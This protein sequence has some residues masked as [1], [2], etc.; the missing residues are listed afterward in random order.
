[1]GRSALLQRLSCLA[2][3]RDDV[4]VLRA[5]AAP[6]EQDF[7]FGVV[8]Q[9]FE[10][11]LGDSPEDARDRWMDA[12]A[13]FARHVLADDAA[14]PGA[15]Q[16][17]AATEAVL[18]GLL[19]LLAN[20]SADSRLLILVDDLQWSDVPSLRWLTYLAKRLHGLRAVVVCALR[21]GDPRSHHTLVREI[22][23]AAT[24]TLRPASLSLTAT[25]ELVREHFGE[26]GDD[27][28]V[29][30]CHEASVGNPLFLMSIL[31]GTGFLGRRP[32]AE[33]A[34]TARRL[35][36]SQLRERLASIL[37]TQRPGP[38][39]RRRHRDPRRTERR[40]HPGQTG[41]ARLDRLRGGPA[42]PRRARCPRRPRRTALHPPVRPRRRRVHPHHGPAG[43]DARR[44][45]RP[46]LRRRLPGRTGRRPAHGRRHQAPAVGRRRAAGRRRH[47]AAPRRP[48]TAAG[49]L[50]RALLDSPAA[51]VGRGRLLVEL[52]TAERGSTPS[53]ANATSPRP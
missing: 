10:T 50:C 14:P 36:P 9:L 7:A 22:R 42:R 26:A 24:Q 27:E 28:F 47:R 29:Q 16:A 34:E 3:D 5:H 39:P 4:R 21:D 11:L 32:L 31:V 44:G 33:H 53:P 25:Q 8:R 17:I 12:H 41:R 38:R 52:G 35:R 46:P 43:A 6:M 49:Y 51:G 19:S 23:E 45:R 1:M 30:A 37:R 48:D 2:D 13:S 40:A 15:D 18:H 20:V